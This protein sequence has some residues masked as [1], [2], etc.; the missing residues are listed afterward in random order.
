MLLLKVLEFVN[1]VLSLQFVVL[2]N[3]SCQPVDEAHLV[4]ENF[5]LLFLLFLLD[6]IV[7]DLLLLKLQLVLEHIF[8]GLVIVQKVLGCE[9]CG[10]LQ[11]PVL[12]QIWDEAVVHD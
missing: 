8:F 4:L 5:N 9:H 10:D 12:A 2:L 3:Y 11:F 7:R 6:L 1:D